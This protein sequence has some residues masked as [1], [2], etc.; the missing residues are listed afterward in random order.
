MRVL[1]VTSEAQPLAK[2][3]GLADVSRALP[4]ALRQRGVDVRILL[5]GYPGAIAQLENPR[6]EVHLEPLLGVENASLVSG[7]LPG[8]NVPVWLIHAPSLFS[9]PGGLYQDALGDDWADNALRF[10][11]LARVGAQIA[12][13]HLVGWQPDIV[14]ANDWH[15]GL[16]PL[17][18]SMERGAKPAT[19]F[20]IHNLAFQGNFP[21]DILQT[22]DIAEQFFT[23]EGVE[24]Y[25]QLSYLKAAIRYSDKITTVS[26]TYAEEVLSPKLGCGLDGALRARGRDFSG[27]LNG[28]DNELWDPATDIHLP[29]RFSARDI[30]GKRL[31]KAEFQQAFGLEVSP[32]IPLIGFVSRLA[33]QKMADVILD[34]VPAIMAAGAQLALVGEGEPALEA[35]FKVLERQYPRQI[36]VHIGY[37]EALAHRLQAG[38][39]VLLAPARFE[40]CGLTQLYALRYGTIPI[41]RHTGGLADTI[42]N[43]LPASMSDRTATGFVFQDASSAALMS[44][45]DRALALY[46]EPLIWRR[47]QLQA[48]ARDFSWDTSAAK[49][50]ALYYEASGIPSWA[51]PLLQI[52]EPA[53]QIAS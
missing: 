43:A 52:E 7:R 45:V 19:I 29:D 37:E 12:T 2:S 1:F 49:Y 34:I 40:P 53:I 4:I 39:D 21:R 32:G 50:M 10:A 44:A 5:P 25:G 31:C 24:F 14:H 16:L 36:A 22:I 9:R 38:S 41:V 27:I 33:H 6:I 35:A 28:I 8:T 23:T 11:F 3:G 30:S 13:G 47:L 46:K 42:T 26:P 15:T 48:M 18:L 17:L 20:T 51:P